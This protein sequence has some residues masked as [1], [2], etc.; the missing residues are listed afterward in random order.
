MRNDTT[1]CGNFLDRNVSLLICSTARI[2]ISIE[3]ACMFH[4][5]RHGVFDRHSPEAEGSA[6]DQPQSGGAAAVTTT[7]APLETTAAGRPITWGDPAHISVA[8]A[9]HNLPGQG[10][11]FS[12]TLPT[13][14]ISLL[15][16]AEHAWEAVANVTFVNTA[17]SG[18]T[19]LTGADIR[20]GLGLLSPMGFIGYT[21][22][23]YNGAAHFVPGTEVVIDDP[24]DRPVTALADGDFGYRGFQATV[25][26]D[27]LH[28]LGHGLGLAH[29]PNDPHA[30]M[31]PVLSAS[32]PYIDRQDAGT[33]RAIYGAAS[34]K[35]IA[36]SAADPTLERLLP[37]GST[38]AV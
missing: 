11:P 20:V 14:F 2:T 25:F 24:Q 17:D 3:E 22:Y 1:R 28:E 26:Q 15:D 27:L 30:V 29:D 4:S 12:H 36:L 34:P 35:A 21:Q 18:T 8:V 7:T 6:S 13:V 10:L 19:T 31:N 37:H 5:P 9:T 33:L 23:S 32:N 16:A 38:V